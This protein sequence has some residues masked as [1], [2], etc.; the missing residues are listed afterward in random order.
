GHALVSGDPI[1]APGSIPLVLDEFLA[2]C[3]EH[4]W[5]PAFLAIREHDLPLYRAR[6]F[7][8][9]YLGDEAIIHCDSFS[10]DGRK[11]K[12]VRQAVARV[13]RSYDFRLLRECD[14]PTRSPTPST[15][16]ASGG[17]GRSPSG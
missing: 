17:G 12:G 3:Q 13:A 9:V 1:G 8:H 6:G 14:A 5:T 10:L 2:F 4:A 15:P 11:M 7:H 16:S